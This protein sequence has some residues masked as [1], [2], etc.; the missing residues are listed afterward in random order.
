[1][2]SKVM[3]CDSGP[4]GLR[5]ASVPSSVPMMNALN[6]DVTTSSSVA[7]TRSQINWATGTLKKY[8][9]PR[10]PRNTCDRYSPSC[11]RNGLSSPYWARSC[12][13]RSSLMPPMDPA[14]VSTG[15]PGDIWISR[16][17]SVT[18][19]SSSSAA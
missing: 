4:F 17:F 18:T 7:G 16:K 9:C 3:P 11:V 6:T 10:S 13:R 19:A 8:E 14:M 5:A 2:D 1:M 12:A 15:S